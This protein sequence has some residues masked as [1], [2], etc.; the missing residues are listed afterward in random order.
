MKGWEIWV[1]R[2]G[3]FTDVVARDPAGRLHAR[4]WLS[5]LPGSYPDATVHAI[6]DLLGLAAGEAIPAGAIADLRIGTTVA[7]NA[8]LERKGARSLWVCNHGFGDALRIGHQARPRLFDLNI[9]RPEPL[10]ED[11][12]EVSGR[13]GADG[14]EIEPL[15]EQAAL[16]GLRAARERGLESVAI[17]LMHAY[18]NPRHEQRLA[19][20]AREAGFTQVVTSHGCSPLIKFVP[21]GE[22]TLAD[23]Y[24]S[25]V[26]DRYLASLAEALG[27]GLRA[28]AALFM[29][30]SGG[31]ARA[32]HFRGKDA[33]LSGPA[34][35]VVG[36]VGT[37]AP[38]GRR[39]LIG[40]DMGGTSTDV[41]HYDGE[42]ERTL[43]GSVAGMRLRTPMMRVHTVAA[44]GGSI[45]RHDGLRMRVGPESAGAYPGPACYGRGGPLTVTDANLVTGRLSPECL[46]AV[47]GPGGDARLDP[48]ASLALLKPWAS[49][50]GVPPEALAEGFLAIAT[51][52]M[53]R[54]IKRVSVERGHD[55]REYTLACFGGAGGQLACRVADALG[56][57]SIYLHRLGSLLSAVGIGMAALRVARQRSVEVELT[58]DSL[59]ALDSALEALAAAATEELLEQQP[60]ATH[61]A[62]TRRLFLKYRG[63]DSAI[64]VERVPGSD[65]LEAFESAHRKEFGYL[66][67]DSPVVVETLQAEVV[68]MTSYGDLGET[69]DAVG[70][71]EKMQTTSSRLFADGHWQEATVFDWNSLQSGTTIDGP[72]LVVG[73]HSTVVIEPGWSGAVEAGGHLALQ[74]Q[75]LAETRT[76]DHGAQADPV[77]LELFNNRFMSIA[78]SM[79]STLERTARSINIRERLDFSCALFDASGA[80]VANAPHMPVHL[81]SM[82]TAVH[83]VLQLHPR[84][85]RGDMY[86]LNDPFHGGTHL[87]DLTVIAPVHLRPEGPPDF[88]VAARGH[89]ADVGGSTPGSMPADSTHIEHEGV[90]MDAFR[91]V[92]ASRFD[93]AGL[94]ERLTSTPL[95]AR[96]P[97]QNVFDLRAQ[98]AACRRGQDALAELASEVGI[99]QITRY[100]SHVQARAAEVV[101]RLLARLPD[102][103]FRCEMD[104]GEVISVALRVNRER[105]RLVVDFTGSSA[106]ARNNFNAPSAVT[107]AAVLYVLRCLV[108]EDIPLNDGCLL[109]VELVIPSSSLLAPTWP[110]ATVAG[111]VETSQVITDALLGAAGALAASQG[112]MNNLTFGNAHFQY[113]ETI[114]GGSGAGPGFHGAS[115]VQTHMTN[116]RM[117][118][119]EILEWRFPVRVERFAV[120]QGSGGAGRWRGGDGAVRRLRFLEDVEVS[121]LGGRRS[122][123]PHGLQGGESAAPGLN[124]WIRS[125]GEVVMLGA[126]ARFQA[127]AGDALEI[128]TPG[129][130]G[131]G[132]P[133]AG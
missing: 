10:H 16:E 82:S 19:E 131:F 110:A 100:M 78:E 57:R 60:G 112:T 132:H 66:A 44:G 23:A 127:A 113:Y 46:P 102:G 101:R 65:P 18:L 41:T 75:A 115:A 12:L 29:Q 106:Q 95:P 21:R 84:P 85:N 20:L 97:D 94:R 11:V 91:L 36:M 59:P 55:V 73:P 79:G 81:G 87:P 26:L 51:D 93:E 129:G 83:R 86:L 126:C 128:A 62:C 80:L 74:R 1:D 96:N 43:D 33:V 27:P 4:K 108:D 70:G 8:L 77:L 45:L 109:P 105:Q 52:N 124:R 53:A 17:T 64:E 42:L 5:E 63:T 114:C 120:R 38:S 37:A 133:P 31:L 35:G 25:P 58:P 111:N 24:L 117:T 40:F 99:D 3:T 49:Q 103:Q 90:L 9:E 2:G 122:T 123:S 76:A 7:T 47:F 32:G 98:V 6:R 34:G 39:R 116:S 119:P 118:D 88:F 22:T 67:P 50:A 61:P 68:A 13:L 104:G 130:G 72:A 30:S 92:D 48:E 28:G 69:S 56:M 15:D 14:S 54:A 71:P 107:R 89:H 125:D 121:L